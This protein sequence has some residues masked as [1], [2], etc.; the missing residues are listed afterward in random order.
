[1]ADGLGGLWFLISFLRIGMPEVFD[2]NKL[3]AYCWFLTAS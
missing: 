1:M 3:S 2:S